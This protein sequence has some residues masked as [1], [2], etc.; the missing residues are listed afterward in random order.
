MESQDQLDIH[1]KAI[2]DI[3]AVANKLTQNESRDPTV[4]S[5]GLMA[6]AGLYCL[7]L[8]VE[9]GRKFN[10][11]QRDEMVSGLKRNLRSSH[12]AL[13]A[14]TDHFM[15]HARGLQQEDMHGRQVYAALIAASAVF[16]TFVAAGNNGF[17][18]P[19]GVKKISSKYGELLNVVT[20]GLLTE[21]QHAQ[22]I[23]VYEK[24][25]ARL[26][27]IKKTR[28]AEQGVDVED[29]ASPEGS[30]GEEPSP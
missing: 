24:N 7:F 27:E 23:S 2:N 6:A 20:G 11:A 10:Q 29:A 26:Q 5:A 17:L 30:D 8:N 16:A 15:T 18:R 1:N 22:A 4:V 21:E 19:G 13:A 28:L 9:E 3:I 12:E 25:L 14:C